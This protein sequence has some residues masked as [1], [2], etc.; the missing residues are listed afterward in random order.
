MTFDALHAA[1]AAL[2]ADEPEAQWMLSHRR[3]QLD[4][5]DASFAAPEWL[6][7]LETDTSETPGYFRAATP[8]ALLD[9]VRAA[10]A[11][12]RKEQGNG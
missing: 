1:I 12:H 10:I 3:W 9:A 11:A 6:D 4:E 8:E 7:K 5:W 2:V